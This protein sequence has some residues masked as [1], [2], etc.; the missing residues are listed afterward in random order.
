MKSFGNKPVMV[1]GEKKDFAIAEF[2]KAKGMIL[3]LFDK[4]KTYI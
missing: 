2:T 1:F 4:Y 3:G